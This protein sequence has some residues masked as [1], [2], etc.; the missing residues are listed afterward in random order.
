MRTIQAIRLHNLRL[1]VAQCEREIGKTWGA[2]AEFARRTG[3]PPGLLSQILSGKAHRKEEQPRR[4]GDDL[5]R[6]IELGM[7]KPEGWMDRDHSAA[8]TADMADHLDNMTLLTRE[9]RDAILLMARQMALA[10]E[11]AHLVCASPRSPATVSNF[12]APALHKL[13]N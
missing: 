9:Q 10:N 11:S 7:L 2:R 3:V 4:I 8:D 12:P 6:A 13:K 5:T 1:L